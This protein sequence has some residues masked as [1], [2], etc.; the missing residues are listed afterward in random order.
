MLR[1]KEVRNKM[2]LCGWEEHNNHNSKMEDEVVL[3]FLVE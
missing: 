1:V 2:M 3:S